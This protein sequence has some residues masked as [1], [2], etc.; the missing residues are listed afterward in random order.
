MLH[1][2]FPERLMRRKLEEACENHMA[3][4]AAM[5][6]CMLQFSAA[7][8]ND[9]SQFS[10]QAS[11]LPPHSGK[12]DLCCST[13]LALKTPLGGQPPAAAA[14]LSNLRSL[15][16]AAWTR[17]G[18]DPACH[19]LD[20]FLIRSFGFQ[21]MKAD[22]LNMAVCIGSGQKVLISTKSGKMNT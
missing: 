5:S 20:W 19:W 3:C 18:I 16:A 22:R 1:F 14:G 6:N 12:K 11:F 9:S 10:H 15:R 21:A 4:H 2:L 13:G 17:S 7:R 8:P